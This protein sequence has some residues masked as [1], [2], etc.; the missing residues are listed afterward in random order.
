MISYLK[1]HITT[2]KPS[3]HRNNDLNTLIHSAVHAYHTVI[4]ETID[5]HYQKMIQAKNSLDVKDKEVFEDSIAN[6]T[7]CIVQPAI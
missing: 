1:L 2:V 6:K 7:I 5:V 4:T 3:H